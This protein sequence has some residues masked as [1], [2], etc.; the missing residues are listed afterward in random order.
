MVTGAR[1]AAAGKAAGRTVGKGVVLISTVVSV[2]AGCTSGGNAEKA[3][4]A[5]LPTGAKTSPASPNVPTPSDSSPSPTSTRDPVAPGSS[6][7]GPTIAA[8][9]YTSS[10][11]AG[12]SAVWKPYNT[13]SQIWESGPGFAVEFDP[14]VVRFDLHAGSQVPGGAGWTGG[15]M[16][17]TKGLTAAWNGGFLMANG[18]SWGGIYLD[19][20]TAFGPLRTNAASEVFYKDGTMDVLSWPGGVPSAAV[21]GVRQNLVLLVSAGQLASTLVGGTS[22]A[23]HDWGYTNNPQNPDANRSAVGVTADGKVI[24]GAVKGASP[25]QL[26]QFM[27]RAGAVRAMQLDINMARP[28]FGSYSGRWSQPVPWMGAASQFTNG[29]QRDF[30]AVYAR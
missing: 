8:P 2:L 9:S 7:T 3:T 18:A 1:G 12:G 6:G 11:A 5:T 15:D 17:S 4:A 21:A 22:V 23:E 20:R 19:G 24:Y 30:V 27:L 25:L 14:S 10:A 16:A 26:A 29:D 28:I 13:G